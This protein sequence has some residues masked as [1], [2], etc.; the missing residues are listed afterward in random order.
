MDQAINNHAKVDYVNGLIKLT[1]TLPARN[2]KCEFSLK[3]LND[4]VGTLVDFLKHEDK[5]IEK[6]Q[7]FNLDGTRISQNTA[8]GSIV[9]NPFKIRIN[10]TFFHLEP[11]SLLGI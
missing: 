3:L 7:V 1:I 8:I 5:S 9:T 10:D 11:P 2:E 6:A 4:T